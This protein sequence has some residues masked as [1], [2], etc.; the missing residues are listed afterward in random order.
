MLVALFGA[1]FLA[2][3]VQVQE[4]SGILLVGLG[5]MLMARG[6]FSHGES[7]ALLPFA[8][9]ASLATAGY[10]VVDGLGARAAGDATLFV[11]WMFLLDGAVFLVWALLL[12]AALRWCQSAP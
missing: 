11:A 6:V 10:S 12:G 1:V 4:Y 8:L 5:I 9:A 3:Q 7:R 2:D